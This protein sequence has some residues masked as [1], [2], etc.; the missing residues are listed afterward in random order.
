MDEPTHLDAAFSKM[1][2]DPSSQQFRL[3]YFE[4]FL[5]CELFLLLKDEADGDQISPVTWE[6]DGQKFLLAFDTEE[7]LSSYASDIA[8]YTAMTGRTLV[9]LVAG[10]Q[11]LGVVVNL[12]VAD[13]SN[14]LP[15]DTILWLKEIVSK[16][17]DAVHR[18]VVQLNAPKGLSEVFV[19]SLEEKLPTM[20]GLADRAY[21]AS[22]QYDDGSGGHIIGFVGTVEG[23]EP[24]LANAVSEMLIFSGLKQSAVD[25]GFLSEAQDM[26]ESFRKVGLEIKLP[27]I[28]QPIS[29]SCAPGTNPDKPP[30]L[31]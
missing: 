28:E 19:T 26:T 4:R 17:P 18:R 30:K 20:A 22:A 5:E 24:A 9:P 13:S 6:A 15:H 29:T 21:I 25:V 23:A 27:R 31:R 16:A 12:D 14:L 8:P 10:N 3:N 11:N 7:R 1:A 2:G